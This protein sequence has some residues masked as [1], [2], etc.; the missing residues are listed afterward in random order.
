MSE[1]T[2]VTKAPR[3]PP[4]DPSTIDLEKVEKLAA[5]R[6]PLSAIA[7]LCGICPRSL[8][9]EKER[10]HA[11]DAAIKRG[12]AVATARLA[13]QVELKI[14]KGDTIMT[15]VAAKQ[16]PEYGGLGWMDERSTVHHSGKVELVVRHEIMGQ[17][18]AIDV[19]PEEEEVEAITD[20]I[21]RE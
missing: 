5:D 6:V 14:A 15:I 8:Q 19:T 16:A 1:T 11:L 17:Q 7:V 18:P 4:V 10:N 2:Q 13:G 20:G 12:R 3:K 21:L 9:N